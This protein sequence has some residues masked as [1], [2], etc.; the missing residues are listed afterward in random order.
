MGCLHFIT[1]CE[2]CEKIITQCK[3]PSNNKEIF[4]EICDDCKEKENIF[5]CETFTQQMNMKSDQCGDWDRVIRLYDGKVSGKN[6]GIPHPDKNSYYKIDYCPWCGEK[7][8]FC[9]KCKD[10]K[11]K[12]AKGFSWADTDYAPIE[13]EKCDCKK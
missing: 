1:I 3:C 4:K 6:Y 2:K 13:W 5:C 10:T 7:L 9:R 11:R 12:P 8:V